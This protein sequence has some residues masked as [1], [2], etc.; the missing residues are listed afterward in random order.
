M[1]IGESLRIGNAETAIII[2]E[3]AAPTPTSEQILET[4]YYGQQTILPLWER[5]TVTIETP[6]QNI[7]RLQSLTLRLGL[8]DKNGPSGTLRGQFNG[9]PFTVDLDANASLKNFFEYVD[10]TIPVNQLQDVNQITLSLKNYST[11]LSHAKLTL[12]SVAD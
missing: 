10:V 9:H 8:E 4:A 5:T 11:I 6:S 3:T 1:A 12:R 7:S 2:V